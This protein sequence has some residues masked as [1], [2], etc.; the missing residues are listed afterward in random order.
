MIEASVSGV[1]HAAPA[2]VFA[3][4]T[5]H[6]RMARLVSNDAEVLEIREVDGRRI[7]RTRTRLP[8]ARASRPS[9]P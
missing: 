9:G 8:N 4:L 5:D 6:A 7:V 3:L 2:D 1:V